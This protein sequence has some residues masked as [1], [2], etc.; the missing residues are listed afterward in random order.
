LRQ[1][2]RDTSSPKNF[3]TMKRKG[4]D[5]NQ[6]RTMVGIPDIPTFVQGLRPPVERTNPVPKQRIPSV[7]GFGEDEV[8]LHPMGHHSYGDLAVVGAGC[9]FLLV[10]G[11]MFLRNG[12]ST[13]YFGSFLGLIFFQSKRDDI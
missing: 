2:L 5:P 13:F 3:G 7:D 4:K 9:V 12:T 11:S 6:V 8:V 1:S 10:P